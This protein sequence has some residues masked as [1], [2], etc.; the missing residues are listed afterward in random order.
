M[1]VHALTDVTLETLRVA[2]V[3]HPLLSSRRLLAL[4]QNP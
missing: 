2:V 3:P 1:L 4:F